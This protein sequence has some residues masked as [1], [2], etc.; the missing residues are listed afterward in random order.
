MNNL[1]IASTNLERLAL[2]KKVLSGT[3]STILIKEKLIKNRLDALRNEVERNKPGTLLLDIDCLGLN[4]TH[5]VIT[6]RSLCAETNTI[7]LSNDVTEELEWELL[8]VGIRGCCRSD[9]K[10]LLLNQVV[11][12]VQQGQLWLRRTLICRL[13]DE[14]GK[15]TS[16]NKAYRDSLS[17]LNKLTQREYDIAVRVRNGQSNKQIAMECAITERTVKAHL[18]EV[19]L[20]MGVSDRLNLALVLSTEVRGCKQ[21]MDSQLSESFARS[22]QAILQQME[23][24]VHNVKI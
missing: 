14:L 20:K 12:A 21:N 3:I 24:P 17:L 9:V 16:K 7:I 15:T 19:F 18:T 2:W 11:A 4:D 13:V 10:P 6:L 1:I 23:N 5:D 22:R 8:K